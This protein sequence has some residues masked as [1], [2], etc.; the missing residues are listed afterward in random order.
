MAGWRLVVRELYERGP[1]R[2]RDL[3]PSYSKDA[4]RNVGSDLRRA[5]ELGLLTLPGRCG[6]HAV[7]RLTPSGIAFAQG[8]LEVIVPEYRSPAR[9]GRPKGVRC[10]L[11]PTWLSALPAAEFQGGTMADD[12][13][14]RKAG[15]SGGLGPL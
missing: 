9:G 8:K 5:A 13:E 10:V 1:L 15:C 6:V 11:R 14:P 2:A 3:R 7:Y 12:R 4:Q